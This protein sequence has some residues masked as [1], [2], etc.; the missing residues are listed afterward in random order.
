MNI[1]SEGS[2]PSP[3]CGRVDEHESHT[4]HT[5]EAETWKHTPLLCPGKPTIEGGAP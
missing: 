1:N 2:S 4:H 3:Y 5:H